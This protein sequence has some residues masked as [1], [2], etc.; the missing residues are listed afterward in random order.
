MTN[1]ALPFVFPEATPPPAVPASSPVLVLKFESF[2]H[3]GLPS[4]DT[5]LL[6]CAVSA[7]RATLG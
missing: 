7:E 5:V 2:R 3:A 4:T 6:P 1:S